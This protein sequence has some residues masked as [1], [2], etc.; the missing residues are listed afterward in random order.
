M[1][2][3]NR[4]WA[5]ADSVGPSSP[6]PVPSPLSSLPS[7]FV[8][9]YPGDVGGANTECWHTV[10][11][12]RRFGLEVSLIP[13]WEANPAWRRKLETIGCQTVRAAPEELDR[14]PG[15]RGS[16]VVAFSNRRFLRE[17]ARFQALGCRIVWLGCMTW[18]FPDERRHYALHKPFDAYVFQS[19]YQ[20]SELQP[21]LARL[22]VR[23]EQCYRIRG[24]VACDELPI[25]PLP[26][27]PGSPLV[28]GRLSR[29]AADKFARNTWS[30]YAQI[31]CPIRARIMAWDRAVER[32]LGP[33]P[34]WAQCLPA[35]AESP[36]QFLGQ[37]HCMMQ[38]N[39]GAAENW[40][41]SGLEAM[42][43]GVPLVAENRWGWREMIR[44]GQTGYLA[45]S[46]DE[47]AFYAA[48]LAADEDHR[49]QIAFRARQ[50]LEEELA[51]PEILWAG[52][53]RLLE[54]LT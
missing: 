13:T 40:P 38:V 54:D 36:R 2:E 37:L 10:Q 26:H 17:A 20:Q 1:Q 53:K 43:C 12:W 11:L 49:L 34:E 51:Q 47:L 24:A 28:V 27:A 50:V 15:L 7:L 44:H 39:G 23:P 46:D 18:L 16:V 4:G 5:W 3:S 48:R 42:A 21:Q 6:P 19:Q 32:K 25:D 45:N 8:A 41:R 22:G 30:V 33:P 52:W 35:G 14:V 31:A 9:G 29:A